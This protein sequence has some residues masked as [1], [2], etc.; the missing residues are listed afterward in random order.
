MSNNPSCTHSPQLIKEWIAFDMGIHLTRDSI[1]EEM[2]LLDP[3]G[4]AL[5]VLRPNHEW[6]GDGHNKLNCIG[7]LIWVGKWLGAWVVPNNW[8][9]LSIA[10]IYLSLMLKLSGVPIQMTTGCGLETTMVYSFGGALWEAFASD[11]PLTELP[12]H[13]FLCRWL[14]L[15]I[16]F[17]EDVKL[18]WNVGKD[19]YNP[20]NP[21]EYELVQWLWST[22][23]QK[24]L[25]KQM[26]RFNNHKIRYDKNKLL[27]SGVSPNVA[28]SLYDQFSGQQ[29][30][31]PVNR[32]LICQL[33][34]ELGGE[35][36]IQFVSVKYATCTTAV[37]D[38]LSFGMLTFQNVW[39][40]FLEMLPIMY[41]E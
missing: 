4:F 23:I 34:D 29:C 9:K 15:R 6:S 19:I 5:L 31:Q 12:A 2:Q 24:E 13:R 37:F 8:L 16:E 21:C 41:P 28:Y 25:D 22:L 20:S 32:N 17:G 33:M 3:D 30:L 1:M 36:L 35:D 38:S 40:V 26:E 10:Y 14:C 18:F 11:L 27:P 7:F 39:E